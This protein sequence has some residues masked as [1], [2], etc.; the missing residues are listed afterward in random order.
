V[1]PEWWIQQ[2]WQA[3]K[4]IVRYFPMLGAAPQIGRLFGPQDFALGLLQ[5]S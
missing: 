1:K 3:G 4:R 2:A 5:W